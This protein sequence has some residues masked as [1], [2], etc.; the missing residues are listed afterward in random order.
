MM[1]IDYKFSITKNGLVML[2]T[3]P[4]E[5]IRIEK[6]GLKEGDTFVLGLGPKGEMMFVKDDRPPMYEYNDWL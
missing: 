2:D 5:M 3:D 4:D 1:Y 6:T